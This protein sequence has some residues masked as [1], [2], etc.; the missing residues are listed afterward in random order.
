VNSFIPFSVSSTNL[1]NLVVNG[2]NN[3]PA[4]FTASLMFAYVT[5]EYKNGSLWRW[6]VT[7]TPTDW[8][9][10]GF[11]DNGSKND[12]HDDYMGVG[13]VRAVYQ[14][15]GPIAGAGLPGA[16]LA[17]GWLGTWVRRRNRTAAKG[18]SAAFV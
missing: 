7:S 14:V 15:P 12:N 3:R 16:V 11:D 9:A 18:R 5:P 8:F 13:H 1:N 17:F 10:F 6:N 4:P 2:D